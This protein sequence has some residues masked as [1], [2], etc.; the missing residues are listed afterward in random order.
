MIYCLLFFR[1]LGLAEAADTCTS[2]ICWNC[3]ATV[4]LRD[5]SFIDCQQLAYESYGGAVFVEDD[6]TEFYLTTCDFVSCLAYTGGAVAV[7]AARHAHFFGFIGHS[8]SAKEASLLRG[9]NLDGDSSSPTLEIRESVSFLGFAISNTI[10]SWL[11]SSWACAAT[12]SYFNS[13]NNNVDLDASG[14]YLSSHNSFSMSFCQFSSNSGQYVI[15]LTRAQD[16]SDSFQCTR[17]FNST[18]GRRPLWA[19]VLG[20]RAL[21]VRACNFQANQPTQLFAVPYGD[22][23]SV[24]FS[25][26]VFDWFAAATSA[27]TFALNDCRTDATGDITFDPQFCW[28]GTPIVTRSPLPSAT[29]SPEASAAPT[30]SVAATSQD[31]DEEG[32]P[33]G[34]SSA[35]IAGICIG[36][37][38]LVVVIVVAIVVL[39]RSRRR[40]VNNHP[41]ET[42]ASSFRSQ[43]NT[44]DE[45]EPTY[46]P[47][48]L[49]GGRDLLG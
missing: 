1:L 42:S 10:S 30:G 9:I 40:R 12:F 24:T 34:L 32:F 29:Q 38:L 21:A 8:C 27:I 33:V 28:E 23:L 41:S 47:V 25:N 19:L 15:D 43:M 11:S 46:A 14:F 45:V 13:S 18:S 6:R 22:L 31:D 3:P 44:Q 2:F 7:L 35:A 16:S 26:C 17:F 4:D 36:V 39:V 20:Y 5:C 37:I 49:G 48:N